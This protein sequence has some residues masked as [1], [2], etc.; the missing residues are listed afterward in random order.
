MAITEHYYTQFEEGKFYHVYNRSIDR[1]PMFLKE[2][3]YQFFLRKYNQ[4][5]LPV[6]DT[7]AYCLL[8]NHFHLLVRI[9]DDLPSDLTTFG[10]MSNRLRKQL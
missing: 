2:D 9:H 3:N 1:K 8:G 5:L 4:Y 7:Y 10:K 6:L